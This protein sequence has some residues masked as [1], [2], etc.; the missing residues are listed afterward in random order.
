[1]SHEELF[2]VFK[3]NL[4]TKL[5][6]QITSDF[7]KEFMEKLENKRESL[8]LQNEELAVNMAMYCN[9]AGKLVFPLYF[10][11]QVPEMEYTEGLKYVTDEMLEYL[12]SII[13]GGRFAV[14]KIEKDTSESKVRLKFNC[15]CVADK[16]EMS[17]CDVICHY[18]GDAVNADNIVTKYTN[19]GWIRFSASSTITTH[20]NKDN[21]IDTTKEMCG[22]HYCVKTVLSLYYYSRYILNNFDVY[23]KKREK[24]LQE[25]KHLDLK[26]IQNH[27]RLIDQIKNPRQKH[28]YAFLEGERGLNQVEICEEIAR[29]LW[30]N[31]KI[32]K[33]KYL[34]YTMINLADRF[35]TN[36]EGIQYKYERF[37]IDRLYVL[38]GIEEFFK[39]F[40]LNNNILYEK[41][42]SHFIK[43]LSEIMERRYVLVLGN[44]NAKKM[45]FELS[46]EIQF[47]FRN[48][49]Y[50]ICNLKPE[51]MYEE[52]CKQTQFQDQLTPEFRE[53]FLDYISMNHENQPIKN[54]QLIKYLVNY[55]DL[56]EKLV[57]P[58]SRYKKQN[59]EDQ[60]KDIIGLE[61]VKE[62]IR[63][64]KD[65]VV[66][67]QKAKAHGMKLPKT[68][69]HMIYTGNPGTGKTTVARIMASMLYQLGVVKEDKLIEVER[70]DLVGQYIGQTAPKTAEVI[71]KAMG[72]VLF[73]DEAYTLSVGSGND[74]GKEAI[75]TLI[76]AME[77][78][79]DE[80]VVIFAGYKKEMDSFLDIN[81]GIA[82]RI[83]YCFDFPDYTPEELMQIYLLGMENMGFS[84]GTELHPH[85]LSIMEHFSRLENFGNGRF[86]KKYIQET[87]IQHS[88]YNGNIFDR[89]LK[90]DL[91]EISEMASMLSLKQNRTEIELD[92]EAMYTIAIH[93]S[94]HA[95]VDYAIRGAVNIDRIVLNSKS[96]GNPGYVSFVKDSTKIYRRSD[97]IRLI[98]SRLAG[99]CAEVVFFGE[100]SD[101]NSHDLICASDMIRIMVTRIGAFDEML[102]VSDTQTAKK[103][104]Y[105]N[106]M[107]N[108]YYQETIQLIRDNKDLIETL[109]KALLE[110]REL[111]A[112][113]FTRIV[114]AEKE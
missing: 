87:L 9:M 112:E 48:N 83:G 113:E 18:E 1:M 4:T 26:N 20:I 72:G 78:H 61:Q 30:E 66:F 106:R 19:T 86:V 95:F 58:E 40:Q 60:L 28:L 62:T 98:K 45:F 114:M 34:K 111:S 97:Y 90:E 24:F 79:S 68:N 29:L 75:A 39:G 41:K 38:T 56:Q 6:E 69:F 109:A 36:T 11:E 50:Q 21:D 102:L 23:M 43:M 64:F 89:I 8:Y 31:N 44:S 35:A 101:G 12:D 33:S 32:S 88:R 99:M 82:S 65:Y 52:F 13:R 10:D 74:Y 81:P 51:E 77:D 76:K 91:P 15:Y 47:I 63:E 57:L 46:G 84:V 54:Q 80:L 37:E 71:R 108:Q 7:Q 104:D 96:G 59:V 110:K 70:K 67:L 25:Q 42:C 107:L 85:I 103:E 100:P 53:E 105:M 17:I 3:Q 94:G 16:K 5:A 14:Y 55:S 93:E 73:V 92:E 2:E 22:K 27:Q 49:T